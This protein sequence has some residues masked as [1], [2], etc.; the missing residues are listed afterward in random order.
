M[1]LWRCSVSRWPTRPFL[2]TG[3]GPLAK[4]CLFERASFSRLGPRRV[5][6]NKGASGPGKDRREDGLTLI[7]WRAGRCLLWDATVTD[8]LAVS[9]L[10]D[11]SLTAGA[12]AER[13]S[14]RK[15]DK[16]SEL[17]SAYLFV[18]LAFETL[19]PI[20]NEGLTFL[21]DLGQKLGIV[22][23]DPRETSYLFQR[24]SLLIQRFNAVAFRG[25]FASQETAE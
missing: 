17:S 10:S 5:P 6:F 22:T 2:R 4:T 16:Y 21:S 25:T 11:T 19:G 23:G 13:A 3:S 24:I 15:L 12:A 20:N 18:P 1:P 8:T 9:Y 7:P 14:A